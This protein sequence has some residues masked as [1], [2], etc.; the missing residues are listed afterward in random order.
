MPEP[1]KAS[2]RRR[3]REIL[4]ILRKHQVIRGITPE[5]LPLLFEDLG[6]AFV[7]IGQIISMQPDIL[8]PQYGNELAKLRTA[9]T[10]ISFADV[11][12]ILAEYG[13]PLRAVAENLAPEPLG[14]A[15][16]AQVHLTALPDGTQAVVK[17]LR[18]GVFEM[19]SRDIQ[20][21]K[22]ASKLINYVPSLSD[23]VD[24]NAMLDE[25]LE[26]AKQETDLRI[27]AANAEEFKR[28]FEGVAYADCPKV[29]AAYE[30]AMV[31]EYIDGTPID[32]INE[33]RANGY[34]LEEIADKLATN[35]INQIVDKGYFHADPHT[36]NLMIN[37]GQIVYIDLGMMG[38]INAVDK[39]IIFG[40]IAAMA[41]NDPDK[42]V[43]SMSRMWAGDE[44]A[45]REAFSADLER[46]TIRYSLVDFAELNIRM[47]FEDVF[48]LARR[49]HVG[50]PKNVSMLM[51]GM[52]TIEGTVRLLNPHLNLAENI[53][54]YF[55]GDYM[56]SMFSQEELRKAGVA[57]YGSL[58]QLLKLPT[59]ASELIRK[60]SQGGLYGHREISLSRQTRDWAEKLVNRLILAWVF[61][62]LAVGASLA[63][64]FDVPPKVSDVP[65]IGVAGYI[66]AALCGIWLIVSILFRRK[67]K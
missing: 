4:G 14:S 50:M 5:K 61:A 42:M 46:L 57:V 31:M 27:E 49:H 64:A 48:A 51:H 18:P 19:M 62:V 65:L 63:F 2:Y 12:A 44:I 16:I 60:A 47:L 32:Q 25:I 53:S 11:Q 39:E 24:L 20:L 15:S 10:P 23:M 38:R 34:D 41:A 17:V 28:N 1:Q 54:T 7:K 36:G 37:D 3:L 13:E 30:K 67:P 43:E 6:P 21:L 58:Q 52:I 59:Q 45:D 33:L 40:A 55:Q 35:Y 8:P 26:V 29:Y 22:R 56:H 66:L 9:V